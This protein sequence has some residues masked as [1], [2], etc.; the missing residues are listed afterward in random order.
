[1]PTQ[2]YTN[3]DIKEGKKSKRCYKFRRASIKI[4]HDL[5]GSISPLKKL[6]SSY[7]SSRLRTCTETVENNLCSLRGTLGTLET[8]TTMGNGGSKPSNK[9]GKNVVRQVSTS[10]SYHPPSI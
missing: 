2:N 4:Y 9:T 6:P 1:M 8:K 3:I 5:N 7:Q 10:L